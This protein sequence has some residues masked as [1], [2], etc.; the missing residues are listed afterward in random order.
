MYNLSD[1]KDTLKLLYYSVNFG[2]SQFLSQVRKHL[3]IKAGK[4]HQPLH[5]YKSIRDLSMF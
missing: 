1:L 3:T 2:K 4:S 5:M